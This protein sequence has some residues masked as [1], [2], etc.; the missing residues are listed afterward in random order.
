MKYGI[1]IRFHDGQIE[2]LYSSRYLGLTKDITE[3]AL[4]N[5][6]QSA[7]DA[8]K[9]L[10]K[11]GHEPDDGEFEVIGVE[12]A[13][14]KTVTVK[15]PPRK[16]GYAIITSSVEKP[17]IDVFFNGTKRPGIHDNRLHQFFG[18]IH[19]ATTFE[20]EALAEARVQ[21]IIAAADFALNEAG[22]PAYDYGGF[23]NTA[24]ERE[25]SRQA[26]IAYAQRLRDDLNAIHVEKL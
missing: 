10:R 7:I 14:Q 3:T 4:Y 22:K 15:Q 18:T 6:E 17:D 24:E 8:V 23:R 11:D 9:L 16:T 1:Q 26:C 13:V 19:R 2:Y 12:Y 25:R 5:Q 21:V 20:T